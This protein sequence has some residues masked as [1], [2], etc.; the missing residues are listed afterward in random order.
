MIYHKYFLTLD[1]TIGERAIVACYRN[2]SSI[3]YALTYLT[4]I[5]LNI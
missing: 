5:R 2:I 4:R 3:Y 1:H